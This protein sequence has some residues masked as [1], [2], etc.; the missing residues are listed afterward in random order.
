[1]GCIWFGV[2]WRSVSVWLWWC[3]IRMQSEAVLKH[4]MIHLLAYASEMIFIYCSWVFH[5]VAV[6]GSLV[7]KNDR[8]IY[9]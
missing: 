6:V 2:C 9:M 8:D 3:G 5:K 7:Q 4:K 1:M